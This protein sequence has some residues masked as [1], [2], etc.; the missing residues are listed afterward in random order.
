MTSPV[1][2]TGTVIQPDDKRMALRAN[3]DFPTYAEA[4]GDETLGF[5]KGLQALFYFN[6]HEAF[7]L[8][9]TFRAITIPLRRRPV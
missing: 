8:G 6:D 5:K 3:F 1:R 7:D 4:Y 2:F 9:E